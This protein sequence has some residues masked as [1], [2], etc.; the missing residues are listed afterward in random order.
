MKKSELRKLIREE[1]IREGFQGD[2]PTGD[3]LSGFRGGDSEPPY[4]NMGKKWRDNSS[5][6]F[7]GE[8]MFTLNDIRKAFEAGI[9]GSRNYHGF[10]AAWGKYKNKILKNR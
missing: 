3:G 1:I 5:D 7:E 6:K 10:G 4:R 2:E 9:K 8:P